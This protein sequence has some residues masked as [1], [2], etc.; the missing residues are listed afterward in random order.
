MLVE[1]AIILHNMIDAILMIQENLMLNDDIA[2][3]LENDFDLVYYLFQLIESDL[4]DDLNII[5]DSE[6]EDSGYES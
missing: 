5:S 3:L 4:Y 6:S 2:Q 1:D